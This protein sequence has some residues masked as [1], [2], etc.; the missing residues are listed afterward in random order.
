M[1]YGLWM[2]VVLKDGSGIFI[3]ESGSRPEIAET[4]SLAVCAAFPS[5]EHC[6]AVLA[7]DSKSDF[8]AVNTCS[9]GSPVR[10]PSFADLPMTIAMAP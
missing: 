8:T 3:D 10:V 7:P 1:I 4:M 5:L 6:A 2:E 9:L